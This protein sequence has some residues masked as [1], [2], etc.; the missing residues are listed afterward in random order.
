MNSTCQKC[1]TWF[2]F[3][4]KRVNETVILRRNGLIMIWNIQPGPVPASR[5]IVIVVADGLEKN[6]AMQNDFSL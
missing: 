5:G 6:Y 3:V 2:D 1:N 4:V